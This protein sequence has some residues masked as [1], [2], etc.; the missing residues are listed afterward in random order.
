MLKTGLVKLW[1]GDS[2]S[3]TADLTHDLTVVFG[4]IKWWLKREM[5]VSPENYVREQ[6]KWWH[7]LNEGPIM[8]VMWVVLN[9]ETTGEM[10]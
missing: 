9:A 6:E 2:T 8:R 7:S 10:E 3:K 4:P 1:H 5:V